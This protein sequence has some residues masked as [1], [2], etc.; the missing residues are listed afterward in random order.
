LNERFGAGESLDFIF[1]EYAWGTYPPAPFPALGVRI[2]QSDR[3]TV[4]RGAAAALNEYIANEIEP[5]V[6]EARRIAQSSGS[7]AGYNRL[8]ILLVRAGRMTEAKTA[9]ERAAGMGSVPA[10]TNRGNLALNEKDYTAAERW[11]R[12]ALQVQPNN[13]SALRGMEQV[14]ENR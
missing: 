2:G 14:T 8:G 12:Q 13:A 6:Q 3:E 5:L 11:Y 4:G 10:M 1:V 9:Y 7:A